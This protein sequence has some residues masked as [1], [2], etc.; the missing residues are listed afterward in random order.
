MKTINLNEKFGLFQEHWSPRVVGELNGQ[1]VKLV[2]IQGEFPW[3]L[4]AG[5][6]ELF[7]VVKGEMGIR[8]RDSVVELKEGEMCIIPRQVEHQ[9]YAEE[10]CWMMLFEPKGTLNT[11]DQE[12]DFTVKDPELI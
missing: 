12:N 8:F 7:F 2:K 5:E 6:D 11:G 1:E 4:H 3:H 9:P 10:E